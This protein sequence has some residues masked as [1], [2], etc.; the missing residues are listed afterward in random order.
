M[1]PQFTEE[2]IEIDSNVF[3]G[4]KILMGKKPLDVGYKN[5]CFDTKVCDNMAK[6]L[7]YDVYYP[8]TYDYTLQPLPAIFIFHPGNFSDC[9]SKKETHLYCMLFAQRGFVAINVE[10]RRGTEE[11]PSGRVSASKALALY[12]ANQDGRG[13]IRS[14]IAKQQ[15]KNPRPYVI[16]VGNIFL[17]GAGTNPLSIAFTQEQEWMDEV[18]PGMKNFLGPLDANYYYGDTSIKYAI[19]GVFNE[20]G[21]LLVKPSAD[22]L[23]KFYQKRKTLP[24]LISFHGGLDRLI[25]PELKFEFFSVNPTF[26][27]ESF[28]TGGLTYTLPASNARV[29][30]MAYVGSVNLHK[31][32]NGF[33]IPSELYI[34]QVMKHSLKT[35]TGFGTDAENVP[36]IKEYI[37]QRV[38]TFFQAIINNKGSEIKQSEF[39]DAENFRY[40]CNM[41]DSFETTENRTILTNVIATLNNKSTEDIRI[42]QAGKKIIIEFNEAGNASV[43][44]FDKNGN[45][46]LQTFCSDKRMQLDLSAKPSGIYFIKV[47]QEGIVR[48]KTLFLQ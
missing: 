17:G 30:D 21:G 19:K 15:N 5:Q 28:C 3:Y 37:V 29:P 33:K 38:A 25:H 47:L 14:V 4:K 9:S 6:D 11:D 12:R 39:V 32:L 48:T 41:K 31:A 40:A 18:V 34:D 46:V 23:E 2:E 43:N 36:A 1:L 45:Q 27:S 44:L 42:I 35:S 13:V 26:R 20:S 8:T 10:Y 22:I 16:D 7:K 24:A